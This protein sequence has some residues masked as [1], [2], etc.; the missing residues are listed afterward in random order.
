[1]VL[2]AAAHF[3]RVDDLRDAVVAQMPG[4]SDA[5]QHATAADY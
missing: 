4:R 3:G 1:M 5:G 2:Q